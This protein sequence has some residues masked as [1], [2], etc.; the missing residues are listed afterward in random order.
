MTTKDPN[1]EANASEST[2]PSSQP[3]DSLTNR[4]FGVVRF[5]THELT[6]AE[7]VSEVGRLTDLS[8]GSMIILILC[9]KEKFIEDKEAKI[10]IF[11]SAHLE[12][13]LGAILK[14]AEALQ[15]DGDETRR[16]SITM[17]FGL[18]EIPVATLTELL[19]QPHLFGSLGSDAHL[20]AKMTTIYCV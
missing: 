19:A 12:Y 18:T 11:P 10:F 7:S 1:T 6:Y 16:S 2:E 3:D 15:E 13:A 4:Q 17:E 5:T 8:E 9:P 14:I 20:V